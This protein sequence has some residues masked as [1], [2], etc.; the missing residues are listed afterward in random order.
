MPNEVA[1]KGIYYQCILPYD[2]TSSQHTLYL[3]PFSV[4]PNSSLQI[5]HRHNDPAHIQLPYYS[6]QAAATVHPGALILTYHN[7]RV[8]VSLGR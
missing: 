2:I 1:S 3:S 4:N 7:N 6:P 5:H 8:E